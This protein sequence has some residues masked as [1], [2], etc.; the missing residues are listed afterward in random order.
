MFTVKENQIYYDTHPSRQLA[1]TI[2]KNIVDQRVGTKTLATT[3]VSDA[4]TMVLESFTNRSI[5]GKFIKQKWAGKN[6]D[7][8]KQVGVQTFEATRFIL[9]MPYDDLIKIKDHSMESDAI[10]ILAVDWQ[11][12]F[13]V[14]IESEIEKYFG[15]SSIAS[16]TREHFEQVQASA[17][18]FVEQII[19]GNA[20]CYVDVET[21]IKEGQSDWKFRLSLNKETGEIEDSTPEFSANVDES[22]NYTDASPSPLVASKYQDIRAYTE[23]MLNDLKQSGKFASVESGMNSKYL[24]RKMKGNSNPE[25]RNM[26]IGTLH[27]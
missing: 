9:E 20:D 13:E 19:Q 16:I 25:Y 11:G 15:V 17:V 27:P 14:E 2:A 26:D 21:F 1:A 23:S 4:N 12:P 7:T 24:S 10:G 8:A 18:Y 3:T 6:D 5:K 22:F